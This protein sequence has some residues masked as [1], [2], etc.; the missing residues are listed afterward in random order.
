[1]IG[2]YAAILAIGAAMGSGGAWWALADRY[3]TKDELRDAQAMLA[4]ERAEVAR[5]RGVVAV[6]QSRVT[7][8]RASLAEVQ[9]VNDQRAA[10]MEAM[11][12]LLDD[13]YSAEGGEVPAPDL[14]LR[15][16]GVPEVE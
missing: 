12:A 10:R 6:E 13:I 14:L 9:R 5:L 11:E 4:L 7:A 8:A 2:R 1:M 16:I 3:A 15:A